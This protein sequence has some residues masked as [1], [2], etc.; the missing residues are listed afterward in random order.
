MPH[1]R[2]LNDPRGGTQLKS[3]TWAQITMHAC[4][5]DIY[6][7]YFLAYFS[8]NMAVRL[9]CSFKG[10]YWASRLQLCQNWLLRAILSCCN[11]AWTVTVVSTPYKQPAKSYQL[12]GFWRH[13]CKTHGTWEVWLC[14]RRTTWILIAS[15]PWYHF[16]VIEV[17]IIYFWHKMGIQ[18]FGFSCPLRGKSPGLLKGHGSKVTSRSPGHGGGYGWTQTTKD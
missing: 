4:T 16:K 15:K 3:S 10:W 1:H 5:V 18:Y 2:T 11:F 14:G 12:Y 7:L 6:R 13:D 9:Y 8:T 17:S